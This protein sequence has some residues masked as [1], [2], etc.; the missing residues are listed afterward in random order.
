M[1]EEE[2]SGPAVVWQPKIAGMPVPVTPPMQGGEQKMSVN[3][4][5]DFNFEEE[6]VA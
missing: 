6:H 4:E 3:L 1:D 5:S 2:R